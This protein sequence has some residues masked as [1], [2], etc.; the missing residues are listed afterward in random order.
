VLVAS[1]RATVGVITYK[2]EQE[3]GRLLQSLASLS[4]PPEVEVDLVVV[5]NDASASARNVVER[6][7]QTLP[8]PARYVVERSR[9]IA[10]ARNRVI[11][12]AGQADLLAFIDDDEIP[13][14][15]WLQEL[16][17]VQAMFRADIVAGPT[18]AVVGNDS[19]WTVR[20][21]DFDGRKR[22]ET[23]STFLL[24]GAGNM[25][26][27]QKALRA[28]DPVFDERFNLTGGE[29]THL[30]LRAN[31]LGL[32]TAW[33]DSALVT[34][35]VVPQRAR[36]RW[37]L[38]R[39]FRGGNTMTACELALSP[40]PTKRLQVRLGRVAKGG[41]RVALGV[42][43]ILLG[44]VRGRWTEVVVGLRSM[45]TGVGMISGVFGF[46]YSEYR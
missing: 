40:D 14:Q 4:L 20:S 39:A 42:L 32:R 22:L 13:S 31:S 45:M 8:F 33:A 15:G 34:E 12:E 1:T 41:F 5:D 9:G 38:K 2:R 30:C 29:D 28:L 10:C 16:V 37:L 3:L 36:L 27:T 21:I 43:R 35:P 26:I 7:R 46:G 19:P 24:A 18:I 25:L 17:R 44:G 23:G 6:L 11:R